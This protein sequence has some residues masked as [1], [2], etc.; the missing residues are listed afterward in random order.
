MCVCVCVCVRGCLLFTNTRERVI[1]I[2]TRSM[3]ISGKK[4]FRECHFL[5]KCQTGFNS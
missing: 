3:T 5:F 4:T 1:I 2:L